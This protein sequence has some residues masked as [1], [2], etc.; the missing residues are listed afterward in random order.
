MY[1][2]NQ[3]AAGAGFFMFVRDDK[4]KFYTDCNYVGKEVS[5]GIGRYDVSSLTSTGGIGNDSISSIKIPQG[6]KVILHEHDFTGR[7]LELTTDV[8]CLIDKSFNDFT[9]SIEIKPV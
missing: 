4:A 3:T 1:Q 8:S 5:L 6:L 9:S 7:K 2:K